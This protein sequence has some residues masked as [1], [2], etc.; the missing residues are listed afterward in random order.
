MTT[1]FE[2]IAIIG[3]IELVLISQFLIA[4]GA[5]TMWKNRPWK[6]Q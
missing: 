5:I 6:K 3:M 1:L 4:L 2:A